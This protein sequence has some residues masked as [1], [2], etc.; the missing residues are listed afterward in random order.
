MKFWD[1]SALV[2]VCARQERT[3]R[4]SV[5][6]SEDRGVAIW[7]GS[8][9]EVASA[10]TRLGREGVISAEVVEAAGAR[11][12]ALAEGWVE[13]EPSRE[14]RALAL[15]LLRVH[16]LRAADALQLAAA[17]VWAEGRPEGRGLVTL[18]GR[19]REAALREGFTVLP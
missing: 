18:D 11:V 2:P 7:W 17:L 8:P 6:L 10:F 1:S 15:R 3:D 14:L 4:L 19:L 13:V 12:E 16:A 9:V 5:L